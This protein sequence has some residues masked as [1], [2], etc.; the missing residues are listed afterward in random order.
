[1]IAGAATIEEREALLT[2]ALADSVEKQDAFEKEI[3]RLNLRLQ[4]RAG[5]PRAKRSCLH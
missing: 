1:M 4:V 3:V 2:V 5:G